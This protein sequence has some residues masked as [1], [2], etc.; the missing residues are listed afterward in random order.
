MDVS[1]RKYKVRSVATA[2]PGMLQVAAVPLSSL[3]SDP[4]LLASVSREQ[5][6]HRNQI[7]K[8]VST[9]KNSS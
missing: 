2:L 7:P 4:K 3:W 5:I 6:S 8:D 1:C 9:D